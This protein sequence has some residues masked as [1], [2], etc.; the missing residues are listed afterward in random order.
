MIRDSA[1]QS[2]PAEPA[3]RQIEVSLFTQAALGSDAHAVADD[4]HADHQLRIDGGAAHPAVKRL[5]RLAEVI[6]GEMAVNAPEHMVGRDMILK[7]EI[8]EQPR[9]RSLNAHHHRLS[10]RISGI[11]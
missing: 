6:E 1:V 7:A 5:Q 8:I 2:E 10:R 9:R 4:Q 11:Q 3:I